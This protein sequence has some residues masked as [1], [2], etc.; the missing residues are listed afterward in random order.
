MMMKTALILFFTTLSLLGS[1]ASSYGYSDLNN[2]P[3]CRDGR[4]VDARCF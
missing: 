2:E 3:I 1:A 4:G